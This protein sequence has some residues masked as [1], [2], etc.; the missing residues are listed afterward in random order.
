M[1]IETEI[2]DGLTNLLGREALALKQFQDWFGGP[3]DGGPNGD[4]MYPLTDGSGYTRMVPSPDRQILNMGS[5]GGGSL[6]PEGVAALPVAPP[7]D[8]TPNLQVIGVAPDGSP[9]RF[10]TNLFA[11]RRTRDLAQAT[12]LLGDEVL[13]S[14]SPQRHAALG[15]GDA[16]LSVGEIAAL[17]QGVANPKIGYGAK[18]DGRLAYDVST[19]RDSDVVES[20]D[21]P[22]SPLDVGKHIWISNA[23]SNSSSLLNVQIV[24]YMDAQHIRIATPALTSRTRQF[25]LWGTDDTVAMQNWINDLGG[26][27]SFNF[28]RAGL[29]P[30]GVFITQTLR[31]GARM[32]IKGQ[33]RSATSLALIPGGTGSAQLQNVNNRVDFPV[34]RDMTLMGNKFLTGNNK[35]GLRFTS[36]PGSDPT[37]PQ[38]DPYPWFSDLDIDEPGSRGFFHLYRGGGNVQNVI[39]RQAGYYG[40]ESQGYDMSYQNVSVAAARLTGIYFSRNNSAGNNLRSW[41]S[42][43]NGTNPYQQNTGGIRDTNSPGNINWEDSCNLFLGS[44]QQITGGRSQESWGPSIVICGRGSYLA[45]TRIDDTGCTYPAHSQ[46]RSTLLSVRAAVMLVGARA[47][48]NFVKDLYVTPAVHRDD[49][50]A[51]HAIYSVGSET[52]GYP[53]SNFVSVREEIGMPPYYGAGVGDLAPG[54]IGTNN[55]DGWGNNAIYVN[56]RLLAGQEI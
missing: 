31:Y 13:A 20:L 11:A 36:V 17:I 24:A 49:N 16:Q 3:A 45:D 38:T 25:A 19:V 33:G 42:F 27:G 8:V 4:G 50:Y 37:L 39:V 54:R 35:D 44:P 41:Y 29:L 53:H 30:E 47:H 10:T 46:G 40:I 18:G 34:I 48:E 43:F 2:L 56:N 52:A 21:G 12:Q 9:K 15:N 14:W 5:S 51:T 7:T 55:P 1:S 26:Q 6:D 22:F 23:G 32:V 28:G